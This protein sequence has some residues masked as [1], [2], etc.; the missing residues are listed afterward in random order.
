MRALG[1]GF[2]A[3]ALVVLLACTRKEAEYR[4][5]VPVVGLD[6]TPG[7]YDGATSSDAFVPPLFDSSNADASF[8]D[9]ALSLDASST[10]GSSRLDAAAHADAQVAADSGAGLCSRA[11]GVL[12]EV[13]G[14]N[15]SIGADCVHNRECVSGA[16]CKE[17]PSSFVCTAGTAGAG[18]NGLTVCTTGN[19]CQSSICTQ[20]A[21]G[22]NTCS[23]ACDCDAD[24]GGKMPKC[25]FLA[26][27]GIGI[28]ARPSGS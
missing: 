19:D 27:L 14:K 21:V 6:A 17:G 24:C 16:F 22:T 2:A 3:T 23:D 4:N 13:P 9:G 12:P 15:L 28:C 11:P 20:D 5:F 1:I 18:V 25:V 7:H 26:F 8:V 10:D